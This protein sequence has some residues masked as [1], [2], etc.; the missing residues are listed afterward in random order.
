[1]ASG[2][3]ESPV[4]VPVT[5]LAGFLGAGKTTRLNALLRAPHGRR[6]AVVL[7]ELGEVGIDAARLQGAEEFVELEGGCLCCALNA[8]LEATLRRL[9]ARGGF[10]HLL[11]ETTGIADP[12]PVAWTFERAGL[13]EGYRLDAIVTVVD[14]VNLARVLTEATEA[15]VQIERADVVL[16]S[17]LDLAPDAAAGL[18]AR[19]RALNPSAPILP[20]PR[21]T[22]PWD[23][24]LDVARPPRTAGGH[25]AHHA[26]AWETWRLRTDA[27]V[28]D[29]ALERFVRTLPP[30][31]YRVKGRVRTDARP[32]W[33]EVNAVGGR[34]EIEPCPA[35][36]AGTAGVLLCIGRGLDR[37]ALDAQASALHAGSDERRET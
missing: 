24:L 34:Y 22:M 37:A 7:N 1:M 30:G 21:D 15:A 18:E 33:V 28:S 10:D 20:S 23:L 13:R 25:A 2:A 12:L 8:D 29:A 31:V 5:V 35:P 19:V 11:V 16:L 9:R 36:P 4:R 27:P 32:P 17:K 3:A 14:A 26:P 6:L